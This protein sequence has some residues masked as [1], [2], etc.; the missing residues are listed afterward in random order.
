MTSRWCRLCKVYG[1]FLML[2]YI[3][4]LIRCWGAHSLLPSPD[5]SATRRSI[6]RQPLLLSHPAYNLVYA[7]VAFLS[8]G[9]LLGSLWAKE[10]WGNY[11]SWDPKETWAVITWMGYLIY[12]H[13]RL[14]GRVGSKSLYVLLI[15]S[16][17]ALQMCWYGVNYLPAAQQS[18]HL[19]NRNN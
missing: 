1:S 9:M 6:C 16:F 10:A 8:I 11:W 18:I 7:G 13:L 17:L 2:L 19:Y 15:F 14:F 4:F 3:C 5:C 12:I